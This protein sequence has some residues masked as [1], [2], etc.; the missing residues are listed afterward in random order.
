M[1]YF[2][3]RKFHF[4][5][6]PAS[7]ISSQPNQ[8]IYQINPLSWQYDTNPERRKTFSTPINIGREFIIAYTSKNNR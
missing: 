3:S 4:L 2:T 8:F 1:M 6:L 7:H 5:F